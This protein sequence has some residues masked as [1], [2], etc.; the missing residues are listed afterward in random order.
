MGFSVAMLLLI[1][2]TVAAFLMVILAG[3]VRSENV[4]REVQ[5]LYAAEAGIDLALQEGAGRGFTGTCGRA[6]FAVKQTGNEM[7]AL[8]Q[9]ERAAGAPV[10]CAVVVRTRGRGMVA[11]SWRQVAP[12][13]R[14]ELAEMLA[15]HQE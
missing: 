13:T 12:A 15:G 1:F 5:A 8:G 3:G 7:A 14:P 10:R 2:M 11:G 6:R 9:V 4:G